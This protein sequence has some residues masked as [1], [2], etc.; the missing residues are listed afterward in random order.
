MT[1]YIACSRRARM[2]DMSV[3]YG[4]W[5]DCDDALGKS[6]VVWQFEQLFWR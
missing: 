5:I 1:I 2:D 4:R 3:Y 6:D